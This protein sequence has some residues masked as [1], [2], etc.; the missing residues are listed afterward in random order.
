MRIW[1]ALLC[2]LLLAHGNARAEDTSQQKVALADESTADI[3]R[4]VFGKP[5]PPLPLASYPVVMAGMRLGEF[6]IRPP[7][8]ADS[9]DIE[10]RF[11][12]QAVIP[13]LAPEARARAEALVKNNQR[14]SFDALR[15]LGIDVTFD[16][17]AITLKVE[18]P[19]SLREVQELPLRQ[20]VRPDQAVELIPPAGVS[21]Y[22]TM[23]FGTALIQESRNEPAGFAETAADVRMAVNIHGVV[24]EGT[25]TYDE[26]RK[27]TFG[28][29]D[30]RLSYDD[31]TRLIRYEAGDLSVP[32]ASLQGRPRI[33]GVSVFR[34]FGIDPYKITQP[35]NSQSFELTRPAR[36]QVYVNGNFVREFNLQGGRYMVRDLPL[37]SSASNDIEL[38]IIYGSGET[39][40]LRFPAFFDYE[41]LEQGLLDFGF[42]GGVPY[43]EDN[44]IRR[45]DSST[46]AVS[47]FLRYGLTKTLTVGANWQG[48]DRTDLVGVDFTWASFL[49][50]FRLQAAGN[51]RDPGRNTSQMSLGY[52]W[53]GTDRQAARS[54]D[55]FALHTGRDFRTL[56]LGSQRNRSIWEWRARYSQNIN[57]RARIQL[58]GNY[59]KNR[60]G[61]RDSYSVGSSFSQ[62]FGLG[63]LTLGAEYRRTDDRSGIVAR[64][65]VTIPFGRDTMTSDFSTDKN[66]ARIQYART[67]DDSVGAVGF[68]AGMD[69]SDDSNRVFGRVSYE[70]NRFRAEVE[71]IAQGY[72]GD[73]RSRDMRTRITAGSS[74]V[75]ADGQFALSRPVY[76]SFAVFKLNKTAGDYPLVVDARTGFG[77]SKT[78]Y[79]ARSGALG[80]AV[81]PDLSSYY[82]RPVQVDA[83]DA[84]PG[85]SLGG[86]VYN[87]RPGYRGGF[88]IKVGSEAAVSAVGTLVDG[89]GEAVALAAGEVKNLTEPGK[90][91]PSTIF[92][93]RAG[94][95]FAEKL[96]PGHRYEVVL[97]VGGT[98]M[99]FGFEVPA[100]ARGTIRMDTPIQIQPHRGSN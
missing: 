41:L 91:P 52:R 75:F 78:R 81:L 50:T 69:R 63:S 60:G 82:V 23:R 85:N 79:G 33:A 92:T 26:A 28:R 32:T 44:G 34:N 65:G 67:P 55:L 53:L 30:L 21:G 10:A 87:L 97:N 59:E 29:E 43:R 36:V 83:P 35:I 22:A 19:N 62:Q 16:R 6:Q 61:F 80:P 48:N 27:H 17:M 4:R 40:L 14:V 98:A 88:A 13:R 68:A 51:A 15:G 11:L 89:N 95:F 76:D 73:R 100:D 93:N 72:V 12:T 5:P 3:Y 84:P 86:V 37:A 94:R 42:S 71:Q 74:L 39:E 38:R 1:P 20:T 47:G 18:L 25:F 31:T 57:E 58:Y 90:Y 54:L 70:G 64:A 96:V 66:T 7:E 45:Y 56:D 24:A 77:S 8:G 46:H 9:G 99:S 2:G 49:G